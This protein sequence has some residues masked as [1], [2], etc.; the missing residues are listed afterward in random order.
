MLAP[1]PFAG[2]Q[3]PLERFHVWCIRSLEVSS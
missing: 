3:R 2:V 1:L